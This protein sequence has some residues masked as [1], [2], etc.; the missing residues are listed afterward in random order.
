[1]DRRTGLHVRSVSVSLQVFSLA[2]A[3]PLRPARGFSH[4]DRSVSSLEMGFRH[5]SSICS[6][7]N[8]DIRGPQRARLFLLVA[9]LR[10]HDFCLLCGARM[11]V[12]SSLRDV[13]HVVRYH[14]N[15]SMNERPT[16]M[17]Y[18]FATLAACLFW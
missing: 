9:L 7:H 13:P 1:M 11:G 3:Q 4:R 6:D 18:V 12:R 15:F 14:F 2:D 16:R 17:A 10:L 5:L 8:R